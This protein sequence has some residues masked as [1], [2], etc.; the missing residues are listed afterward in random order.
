MSWC[1][2]DMFTKGKTTM[3]KLFAIRRL[4]Q[5]G[6]GT[7]ST[8]DAEELVELASQLDDDE[9]SGLLSYI[10]DRVSSGA[11]DRRR[12]ANDRRRLSRDEPPPF[13]G[14]PVPGGG[15]TIGIPD[16]EAL[17]RSRRARDGSRSPA[18]DSRSL[19]SFEELVFGGRRG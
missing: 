3:P 17:D 9:V 8:S 14:R 7:L 4:A 2:E 12:R 1:E 19:P 11:A 16:N 18:M 5:D 15:G 6:N 10:R 13:P